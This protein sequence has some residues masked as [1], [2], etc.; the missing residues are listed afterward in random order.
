MTT[1]HPPAVYARLKMATRA[2]IHDV[3]GLDCAASISRSS[4]ARLSVM[5]SAHHPDML[6][7]DVAVDLEASVNRPV[8][9]AVMA[10][11]AGHLLIP[12][13]PPGEGNEVAA[14][15]QVGR[16][17]GETFAQWAAAMED[18]RLAP[19]E[20]AAVANALTELA[21]ATSRALALITQGD[22]P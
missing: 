19:R 9:T 7:L 5:Q 17:A 11:I 22:A 4:I 18:G 8:V 3:G 2:L 15:A 20:R 13:V 16:R 10:G 21:T 14:I 6:P 12:L 1:M